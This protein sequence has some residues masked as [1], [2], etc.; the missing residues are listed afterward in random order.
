MQHYHLCNFIYI[1]TRI[2]T[3]LTEPWNNGLYDAGEKRFFKFCVGLAVSCFNQK[4]KAGPALQRSKVKI[5][6]STMIPTKFSDT[7]K[8]RL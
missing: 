2:T 6:W 3:F 5:R 1:D 4:S 7:Q 8:S